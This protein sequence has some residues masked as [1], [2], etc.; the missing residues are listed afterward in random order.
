[1]ASEGLRYPPGAGG[2]QAP[3]PPRGDGAAGAR[4]GV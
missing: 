3:R 1:M 2:G 4:G